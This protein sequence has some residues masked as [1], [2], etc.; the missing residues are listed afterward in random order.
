MKSRYL[1]L[2]LMLIFTSQQ[3][4]FCMQN[5]RYYTR[6]KTPK[7]SDIDTLLLAAEIVETEYII[8]PKSSSSSKMRQNKKRKKRAR[9]EISKS[10]TGSKIK[11][12]KMSKKIQPILLKT[13]ETSLK[14]QLKT[15]PSSQ[16]IDTQ[17][18]S[19]KNKEKS[20]FFLPSIEDSG[21]E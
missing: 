3:N 9:S 5:H 4:I 6:S 18:K 19:D 15:T 16:P 2:F 17:N 10:S 7:R 13:V 8:E 21:A 20:L 1:F 12:K 14:E 11:K